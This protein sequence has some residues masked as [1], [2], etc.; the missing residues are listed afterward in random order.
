MMEWGEIRWYK[1][2]LPDK[3]RPVL[4][5]TRSSIIQYLDEVTIAPITSTIRGIPSEVSLSS[6]DGMMKE[7]TI[8]L[9]HIQTIQKGK[10]GAMITKLSYAK[11]DDVK[12]ALL[13]ALG[14]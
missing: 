2:Q 1:F 14:F 3:K 11:M 9:D 12:Q 8:N 5:L 10:L 7:C 13:F 6:E 4:I